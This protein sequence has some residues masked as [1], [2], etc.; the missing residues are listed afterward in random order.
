VADVERQG[1]DGSTPPDGV[2]AEPAI[3]DV[4]GLDLD[5][6]PGEQLGFELDL[7]LDDI[8][9]PRVPEWVSAAEPEDLALAL[10]AVC[11]VLNRAVSLSEL[12]GILGRSA[13]AVGRAADALASQVRGRGLMLQRHLDQVQLVTRPEVAWA[14]QRALNPEKP[15]RLSRPALETLAIVA[16]RQPVTRAVIES[17]RGVNCETVLESLERRGLVIEVARAETPGQPRLFGT[18]LRFLQ[19]VGLETID[20]LPAVEGVTPP[21]P[22]GEA[23]TTSEAG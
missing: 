3:G 9:R 2:L 21:P 13:P 16:Y 1:L 7:D 6:D 18:T 22:D 4:D 10:E 12:A 11:F 15:A 8:G 23:V 14:V 5:D 20:Q 19:L 17:I